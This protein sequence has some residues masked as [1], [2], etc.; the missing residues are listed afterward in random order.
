[1]PFIRTL[2]PNAGDDINGV[3]FVPHPDGGKVSERSIPADLAAIFCAVPGFETCPDPGFPAPVPADMDGNDPDGKKAKAFAD[4]TVDEH[5][6]E[7]ER[8]EALIADHQAAII[9]AGFAELKGAQ[10]VSDADAASQ[11][12]ADEAAG[13]EAP[14]DESG[15][16]SDETKP[17]ADEAKASKKK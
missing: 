2:L 17:V 9:D 13:K 10:P 4:L 1:M 11:P 16:V 3:R 14:K 7:I 12:P 15:A 6:D 8:L 5:R